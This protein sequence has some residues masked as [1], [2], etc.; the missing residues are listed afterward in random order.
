MPAVTVGI[1]L[2][3]AARGAPALLRGQWDLSL[4]G[5]LSSLFKEVLL[6]SRRP[7]TQGCHLQQQIRK[8]L[9][10]QK[11]KWRL[12]TGHLFSQHIYLP[13]N[14]FCKYLGGKF[15]F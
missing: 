2:W 9:Q 4:A 8:G 12:V 6:P 3:P 5:S 15:P 13:L 1:W 10:I 11:K 7:G 14:E